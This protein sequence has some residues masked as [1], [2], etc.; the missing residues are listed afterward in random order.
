MDEETRKIIERT[1]ERRERLKMMSDVDGGYRKRRPLSEDMSTNIEAAQD[2]DSPKR[3]CLRSAERNIKPDTPAIRGVPARRN[4]L[5]N[6]CLSSDDGDYVPVPVPRKSL[7]QEENRDPNTEVTKPQYRSRLAKLAQ[8]IN[9][10]DDDYSKHDPASRRNCDNSAY[11]EY[12]SMETSSSVPESPM[13]RDS[14][15]RTAAPLAPHMR[16]PRS[17][18]AAPLAPATPT[19][20]PMRS[21]SPDPTLAYASRSVPPASSY[22]LEDD[23]E[24][25]VESMSRQKPFRNSKKIVHATGVT[26]TDHLQNIP[27]GIPVNS[28]GLNDSFNQGETTDDE[29]TN[30]PVSERL[31]KWSKKVSE[32]DTSVV[33]PVRAGKDENLQT[34]CKITTPAGNRCSQNMSSKVAQLEKSLGIPSTPK[35]H[36]VVI[37]NQHIVPTSGS[38][39]VQTNNVAP[40]ATHNPNLMSEPEKTNSKPNSKRRE[41]FEPTNQ[42]VSQRMAQWQK[43]VD[44]LEV[45]TEKEPTA[46][47]V[48]ARMSAWEQVTASGS[49]ESNKMIKPK[50]TTL[51]CPTTP[52]RPVSANF[53]PN[54]CTPKSPA[55]TRRAESTVIQSKPVDA[56]SRSPV[57]PLS[58]SKASC[59]MKAIQQRLFES[60]QQSTNTQSMAE[61]IRQERM[62]ELKILESRWHKGILQDN[63]GK[64]D[65]E[66]DANEPSV[67]GSEQKQTEPVVTTKPPPPVIT[68]GI[69]PPAPPLPNLGKTVPAAASTTTAPSGASGSLFKLVASSQ[70]SAIS[71]KKSALG[72]FQDTPMKNIVK[73][74]RF[75]DSFE[76]SDDNYAYGNYQESSIDDISDETD[77]ERTLES[78]LD[79]QYAEQ[80]FED[81][82]YSSS[83]ENEALCHA[84]AAS[85]NMSHADCDESDDVSISAFVPESVR[86]QCKISLQTESS[87]NIIELAKRQQ[88]SNNAKY[89]QSAGNLDSTDDTIDG[90]DDSDDMGSNGTTSVDELI[91]DA[92]DSDT[93]DD[94][95]QI[96]PTTSANKRGSHML[97][98]CTDSC[99]DDST[100]DDD[101]VM[102]RKGPLL[103]SISMY[104]SKRF[105]NNLTPV[106]K[107]VRNSRPM[108]SEEELESSKPQVDS[109]KTILE[110]IKQLSDQ[111]SL[112]Q[113]VILQTSN[114]LNQ[115]CTEGSDFSGSTQQV[116]CHKLLLIACQKRRA[117]MEEIQRL[118]DSSCLNPF[119][120]GTKGTLTISDI[121]LPLKK[122]FVSRLSTMYDL[123]V[124]YYVALI[125]NGPLVVSTQLISTHDP[126]VRGS[127][128]FPNMIKLTDITS[129]FQVILELYEMKLSQDRS[130]K[131]KK[132]KR[133]KTPS[134][135]IST[136]PAGPTSIHSSS[137]TLTWSVILKMSNIDKTSFTMDRVP[138]DAPLIG[139]IYL[140]IKCNMETNISESGFLTM[141]EDVSGLGAWHRRW[142]VLSG[143]KLKYWKYPDDEDKKG[144]IGYIELKRCITEKVGLISRDIC[145]RP[146][147]FEMRTVRPLRP[148][149]EDTLITRKHHTMAT[150]RHM[151]SADTKEERLLWCNK[152]NEALENVRAWQQDALKPISAI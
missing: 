136:N 3:Q 79:M 76:S 91:D 28:R 41:S 92:L 39:S 112:E 57:K 64:S 109:R 21:K 102:R 125:R 47:P 37:S 97:A 33:S 7:C 45:L 133:C 108:S 140:R 96:T 95:R 6:V 5:T 4:E 147:T 142:C 114:A 32:T 127:L 14:R 56:T 71:D 34:N 106:Q 89:H 15:S 117:Y 70:K 104:R 115:C 9:A 150:I 149:E 16:S 110:R 93:D 17:K 131:K 2:D 103:Y 1:K 36:S 128:D 111:V 25:A 24:A 121:R 61:R 130:C 78:H 19:P 63:S 116:E 46:Y 151:L 107:I 50:G 120:P 66:S 73:Q 75:E 22:R 30:K 119:G 134:T 53:P 90:D 80:D 8:Q 42:P 101:V 100:T 68:P 137:F 43:K 58:P 88:K 51:P 72:N 62:A 13:K 52:S 84:S 87:S 143:N 99:Y 77:A 124:F 118:K 35:Q 55:M 82:Y 105:S 38:S 44:T 12:S 54:T 122:D 126:M 65:Q 40:T 83:E 139:S 86:Q 23:L 60:Q 27:S 135:P 98:T 148:G 123:N 144:P 29:P 74:V 132:S 146:N 67:K 49:T 85:K 145:A 129:K 48:N 113:S 26:K 10:W 141:F 31:A 20:V 138:Y 94:P 59:A 81:D 69:P 152:L 18:S 11:K